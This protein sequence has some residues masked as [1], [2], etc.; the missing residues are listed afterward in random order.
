ME[1]LNYPF[2]WNPKNTDVYSS[3][4]DP[5]FP[6]FPCIVWVAYK[7]RVIPSHH[8]PSCHGYH[9]AF[10]ALGDSEV[11]NLHRRAA[12]FPE[13]NLVRM[14]WLFFAGWMGDEWEYGLTW[15]KLFGVWKSQIRK[16]GF[17]WLPMYHTWEWYIFTY[18]WMVDFYDKLVGKIPCIES[19]EDQADAF[20]RLREV[21]PQNLP[22]AARLRS[23]NCSGWI[24]YHYHDNNKNSNSNSNKNSNNNNDNNDNNNNND[25]N[26]NNN[27]NNNKL[28][29][30]FEK[31]GFQ[32]QPPPFCFGYFS[33]R[34]GHQHFSCQR[35]CRGPKRFV[36]SGGELWEKHPQWPLLSLT[37]EL[38]SH[39]FS[40]N[41]KL[42]SWCFPTFSLRIVGS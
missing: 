36:H 5:E 4:F 29:L 39:F 23:Y 34:S 37:Y 12:G 35:L 3:N 2:W 33:D 24:H 11:R 6:Y 40:P 16:N 19:K 31:K 10:G 27:N 9:Q 41:A 30:F 13:A 14:G 38:V 32:L 25:N 26:D 18:T 20:T 42:A 8:Q 7:T 1:S 21:L 15:L 22:P 17:G 28:A